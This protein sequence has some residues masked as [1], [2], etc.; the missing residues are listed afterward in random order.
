LLRPTR[1]L[2]AAALIGLTLLAYSNALTGGFVVDSHVLIVED[3]RLRAFTL[4]N[5][6]DIFNHS[7]WWPY[8][9]SNL[10][11]PL[12]TLSYLVNYSLLRNSTQP[13]GYHVT[14]IALHLVNVLL[15]YAIARRL[16]GLG[17]ERDPIESDQRSWL[18]LLLAAVW[19]VHPVST[20]AV[21]YIMGRADLLAGLSVLGGFLCY[22][23]AVEDAGRTKWSWFAAVLGIESA[24]VLAKESAVTLPA[25][26]VLYEVLMPRPSAAG[27]VLP[28]RQRGKKRARLSGTRDASATAAAM[29]VVLLLVPIAGFLALRQ[30][31][32]ATALP[33]EP[34]VDNP[35][36]HTGMTRGVLTATAVMGRYLW[37]AA[38]PLKLSSDYSYAQVPLADGRISDWAAWAAVAA[39]AAIAIVALL[40]RERLFAF[41]LGTAFITFLPT[42]NLLFPT[43][44][45]MAERLLYLPLAG[46]VGAAVLGVSALARRVHARSVAIPALGVVVLL[47]GVRTW[48]RNLDW[49]DDVT[50]WTSAV[51]ASPNSFKAHKGLADALYDA[52]PSNPD[53]S[54]ITS[55]A[56][57]SITILD[58][59]PDALNVSSAYRRAIGFFLDWGDA[60]RGSNGATMHQPAVAYARA[61]ALAE[62]HVAIVQA[63]S[64]DARSAD[65]A[66][67]DA[68][69]LL[70]TA[71]RRAGAAD[72][73]LE[74][75]RRALLAQPLSPTAYRTLAT[76]FTLV[77]QY[78]NAAV[79]LLTGFMVTGDASL[80]ETLIDVYRA[81]LDANGCA[82]KTGPNGLV[83]N[84]NCGIVHRHLCLATDEAIRVQRQVGRNELA[85]QLELAAARS[86]GCSAVPAAS[87][88]R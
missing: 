25:V 45:I 63:Q 84:P 60:L 77:Q 6:S 30:S 36:A 23:R 73:S 43:G 32:I 52:N 46:L 79:A 74:A 88:G 87:S 4:H 22:L 34:F 47:F 41:A 13:F 53:W 26:I 18:V 71:Y 69:A 1:I 14:N 81:G 85:Q 16:S 56:D 9:D 3:P 11:R 82:V 40:R 28:A 57:R 55:E 33:P 72:K 5:L 10:Y 29:R 65:A 2:A 86:Y 49:R 20:E 59:L 19:A 83:L 51:A 70:A 61:V 66:A 38:V 44:T 21:T 12:T 64:R 50:L 48:L 75:A 27:N 54:R 76:S 24:G 39:V 80:R 78:D 7:Y 8:T 31:A 62:R 67:A 15:L 68:Q 17:T 35:I 42:S 37:L 58:P